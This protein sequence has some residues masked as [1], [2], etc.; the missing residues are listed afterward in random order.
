ML[1]QRGT[2]SA[3]YGT[4]GRGIGAVPSAADITRTAAM[5][6]GDVLMYRGRRVMLLGLE[7]MSVPDPLALVRDL[8]TGE[9]LDVPFDEL[10]GEVFPP[11][12]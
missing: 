10:E 2:W 3:G 7:P 8:A 4:A 9:E 5:H 11:T 12:P 6:I 1:M